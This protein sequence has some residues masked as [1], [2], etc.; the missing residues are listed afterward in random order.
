ME[1]TVLVSIN[2]III[3]NKRTGCE[4]QE[5]LEQ[6]SLGDATGVFSVFGRISVFYAFWA[7]ND[8]K[9]YQLKT[10]EV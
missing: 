9:K 8:S 1:L 10:R 6:L 5:N 2:H 7:P 3:L 4:R